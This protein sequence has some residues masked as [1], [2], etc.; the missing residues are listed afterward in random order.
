MLM[1]VL[2]VLFIVIDFNDCIVHEK[3]MWCIA[4]VEIYSLRILIASLNCYT[5]FHI[6]YFVY[7]SNFMVNLPL[8]GA[9]S[10]NS[11]LA[12]VSVSTW[13]LVPDPVDSRRLISRSMF[14]ILILTSKKYILPMITSLRWYL[15]SRKIPI[16]IYNSR[17]LLTYKI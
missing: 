11:N 6:S 13:V 9:P 4:I 10:I 7:S 17:P 15:K 8:T 5:N 2:T 3:Q 16:S 1:I 12:N 14:F